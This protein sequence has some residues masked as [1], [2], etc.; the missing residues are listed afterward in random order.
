MASPTVAGASCLHPR[1]S[2][3]GSFDTSRC[4]PSRIRCSTID[5]SCGLPM[6]S[7]LRWIEAVPWWVGLCLAVIVVAWGRLVAI[8][9]MRFAAVGT[10]L[11]TVFA[12]IN[13]FSKHGFLAAVAVV[14][15]GL[16]VMGLLAK[17]HDWLERLRDEPSSPQF[18]PAHPP[19]EYDIRK[20]LPK[21]DWQ[22]VTCST[23]NGRGR[24]RCRA[25]KGNGYRIFNGVPTVCDFEELCPNACSNGKEKV[26]IKNW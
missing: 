15:V 26:K 7:V 19:D 2:S 14:F 17:G 22:W 9:S 20:M 3:Y 23:C 24:I 6:N 1:G 5:A 21:H 11:F 12:A 25:C 18:P 10:G 16:M 13:T 8:Y 4:F